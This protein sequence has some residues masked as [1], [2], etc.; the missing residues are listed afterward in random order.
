MIFASFAAASGL[1]LIVNFIS[2]FS[3]T[4]G[5]VGAVGAAAEPAA[6]GAAEPAGVVGVV[7]VAGTGAA[8]DAPRPS[9]AALVSSSFF[10]LL[11]DGAFASASFLPVPTPNN[12]PQNT[13]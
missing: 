1:I 4:L 3:G 11:A 8:F 5:V 10:T 13:P 2:F 6:T 9:G 7:G 12:R